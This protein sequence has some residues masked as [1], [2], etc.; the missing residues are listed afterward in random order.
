LPIQT[1]GL[2]NF[3][4][5]IDSRQ[6][7]CAQQQVVGLEVAS[8]FAAYALDF[9][10]VHHRSDDADDAGRHAIL[11]VEYVFERTFKA[12]R[13]EMRAVARINELTGNAQAITRLAYTAL[14]DIANAEFT[15]D[16]LDVDRF[17]FVGEA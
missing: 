1:Q 14:K 10:L 3:I 5:A 8:G 7:L 9:G 4:S 16:L 6:G 17:A 11:K 15:S 13:P 12:V 2:I